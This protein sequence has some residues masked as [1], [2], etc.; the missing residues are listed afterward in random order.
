MKK[1]LFIVATVALVLAVM[2]SCGGSQ[3]C[4]AYSDN[5]VDIEVSNVA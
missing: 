1:I 3:D 2:S 5:N 4:P